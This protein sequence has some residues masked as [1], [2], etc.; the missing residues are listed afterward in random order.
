MKLG[1]GWTV[2]NLLRALELRGLG[3]EHTQ[4]GSKYFKQRGHGQVVSAG[5]V[6]VTWH[7]KSRLSPKEVNICPRQQRG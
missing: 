5:G 6:P 1:A 4:R 2:G 3:S 7:D